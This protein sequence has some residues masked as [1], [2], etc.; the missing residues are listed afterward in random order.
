M[1][2]CWDEIPPNCSYISARYYHLEQKH[3]YP[4]STP[5]LTSPL[6]HLIHSL[7]IPLNRAPAA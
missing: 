5:T 4:N 2:S 3:W 1:I 6:S 7:E